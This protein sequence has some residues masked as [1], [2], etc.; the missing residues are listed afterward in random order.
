MSTTLWMIIHITMR[1]RARSGNEQALAWAEKIFQKGIVQTGKTR[2]S[3]VGKQIFNVATRYQA[4][5]ESTSISS[6]FSK[7]AIDD[8]LQS[9][10][11][12]S[13]STLPLQAKQSRSEL[14][15]STLKRA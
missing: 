5:K 6:L 10:T 1:Q 9:L 8:S 15:T 7:I 4:S 14:T 3:E 13:M 12:T 11:D 2:E